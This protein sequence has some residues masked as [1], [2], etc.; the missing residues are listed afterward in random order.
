[1][2]TNLAPGG[3]PKTIAVTDQ[4]IGKT[5]T[6]R[7]MAPIRPDTRTSIEEL[8]R[9]RGSQKIYS[10][11]AVTDITRSEKKNAASLN[12]QGA[13]PS[14][15][16]NEHD[17]QR[18]RHDQT[19]WQ[20]HR[21][22][23]DVGHRGKP[24]SRGERCINYSQLLTTTKKCMMTRRNPHENTFGENSWRLANPRAASATVC[25]Y[26]QQKC[27]SSPSRAWCAPS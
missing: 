12:K 18:R 1:M 15:L 5:Q 27:R 6:T 17:P 22:H 16:P 25:H 3:P 10:T 24:P 7:T 9:R 20:K 8:A 2:Y 19:W 21:T 11:T 26:M 4:A 14:C 23:S 13:K